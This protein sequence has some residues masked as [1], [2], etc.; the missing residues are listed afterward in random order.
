[1]EYILDIFAKTISH[2]DTIV[3]QQIGTSPRYDFMKIPALSQQYQLP[4]RGDTLVHGCLRTQRHT[5]QAP[6]LGDLP[7]HMENMAIP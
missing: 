6:E 1:M 5:L 3:K 7:S 2:S 4:H